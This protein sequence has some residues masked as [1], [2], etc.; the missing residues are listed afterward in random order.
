MNPTSNSTATEFSPCSIKTV[1]GQM[2]NYLSCLH[3]KYL[4]I[5]DDE[6]KRDTLL[7]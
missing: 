1:C 7:N 3:G 5:I 2:S 4:I 6:K